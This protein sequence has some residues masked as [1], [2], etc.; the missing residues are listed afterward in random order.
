MNGSQRCRA[1]KNQMP[2]PI[3]AMASTRLRMCWPANDDRRAADAAGQL[4]EGDH[5]AGEGDRADEGADEELELVARR[6]CGTGR[7]IDAGLLT[8]AMAISTAARPTSECIAATSSGICVIC[9][10]R[11]TTAPIDAA[12]R[13]AAEDHADVLGVANRPAR[14]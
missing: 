12:D 10:R 1:M 3:I 5:R 2:K 9:T 14:G 4:A 6:A 8:A 7:P 13:H 11:A